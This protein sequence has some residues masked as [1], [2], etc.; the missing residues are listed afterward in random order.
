MNDHFRVLVVDDDRVD[1]M[2]VVRA[3]RSAGV[4]MEAEEA[5]SVQ[6]ARDLLFSGPFDCV[7][8]DYQLPGGDGLR[9]V[10]EAREQGIS[11]PIV[12][13]TGQSDDR[14]AVDLM[15]AG[16][17]DYL[18]KDSIT[19]ER[20]EQTLRQVVRTHRAEVLVRE[21]EDR[22]RTSEQR[23]RSL[24]VATSQAVW[25]TDAS[26]SM[27]AESPTWR[28]FTGQ[29]AEEM[30][31]SG[32]LNAIHSD[33]REITRETW[34]KAIREG[35][36]YVIEHRV[37]GPDGEYR[38]MIARGVPVRG[39]DGEVVEWVGA[40]SDISRRKQAELDR[41]AAMASRNRFYAAMS[42]EIRTPMN[43]ILGYTDLLLAGAYG[44][45]SEPQV[46]GIKRTHRAG[47][48]LLEL[49][50]DV[51]DLSKLEAG[52]LEIE[53]E[54]TSIP[55]LIE[56]LFATVLPLARDSGADLR[57]EHSDCSEPIHIDPRRVRQILLNLLSNAI[58]FGGPRPVTV[59]CMRADGGG[60]TVEVLDEGPGIDPIDLPRIFEEFVQL[61]GTDQLGT[62][63]GLPISRRLAE[64]LGGRLDVESNPGEGSV[65]RLFLPASVPEL[66]KSS[67]GAG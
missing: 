64:L 14:V 57:L 54:P 58:K 10:R 6:E 40:H 53:V 39:S 1:R 27:E 19:P 50:N 46:E 37:R 35:T 41:E 11:T 43:A 45:M 31:G 62:G 21:A 13:L 30:K 16:A 59:R 7:F 61:S 20:L 15:K 32:W 28:E 9:V 49:V 25:T 55:S 33:D 60:V 48:H 5:G 65:F 2:A 67:D 56:D 51:L 29:T 38:F 42:H 12:M 26:G 8:L 52:K 4:E 18:T 36:T 22:V 44:E 34:E 3:L 24:V 23:F 47:Q 66:E 17:T 63:L